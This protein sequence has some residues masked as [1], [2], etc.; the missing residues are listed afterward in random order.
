MVFE[1]E[2]LTNSFHYPTHDN[3][4]KCRVTFSELEIVDLLSVNDFD[5]KEIVYMNIAPRSMMRS[6]L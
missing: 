1:M 3:L 4:N 5:Y 2:N 6:D